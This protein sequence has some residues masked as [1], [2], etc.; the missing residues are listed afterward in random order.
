MLVDMAMAGN[1]RMG[2]TKLIARDQKSMNTSGNTMH[3]KYWVT[4]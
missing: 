4:T 2:I 3:L 1:G